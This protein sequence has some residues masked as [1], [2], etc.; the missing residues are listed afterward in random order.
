MASGHIADLAKHS[1]WI[2]GITNGEH[3]PIYVQTHQIPIASGTLDHYCFVNKFGRETGVGTS[4]VDVNRTASPSVYSW[5]TSAVKLEAISSSADDTSAGSGARTI[6]VEGLD[7]NLAKISETITMN[8]AS[9]STATTQSFF[10][11][12]RAYVATS[13]SYATST[14]G[15]HAGNITIRTVSAG[16]AHIYMPIADVP[17]GQSEVAR[18]TVPA[19]CT[20]YLVHAFFSVDSTKSATFYMMRRLSATTVSAPYGVKRILETFDGIANS[21]SREWEAPIKLDEGTDIWIAVKAAGVGT[22][23]SASF[24]LIEMDNDFTH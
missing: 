4:V 16:A 17:T 15:S 6:V 12:H 23:V 22:N 7:A 9:A 1:Y 19:G 2:P 5:P 20:A 13:G 11:V 10:R 14:S 21:I 18:Y 24:D 3:N 8:G